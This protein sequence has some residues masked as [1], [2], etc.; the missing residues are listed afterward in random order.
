[1]D[2]PLTPRQRQVVELI[3]AGLSNDEIGEKLGIASRTVK[4]HT[5]VLRERLEVGRRREIPL[6]YLRLTGLNPLDVL[7]QPPPDPVA[8]A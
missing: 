8:A 5:D 7:Q 3:A 2:F 4:A 6:A 1:M